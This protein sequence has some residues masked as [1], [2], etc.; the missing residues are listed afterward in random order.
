MSLMISEATAETRNITGVSA[1]ARVRA[2][3]L[4]VCSLLASS[5]SLIGCKSSRRPSVPSRPHRGS[6]R[7]Q[8]QPPRRRTQPECH[9]AWPSGV[10]VLAILSFRS[11]RSGVTDAGLPNNLRRQDASFT[12]TNLLEPCWNALVS[13]GADSSNGK[14][15]TTAK[16]SGA[17]SGGLRRT[18]PG[19]AAPRSTR[20][21]GVAGSSPLLTGRHPGTTT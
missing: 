16:T 15:R 13:H 14:C 18:H 1:I 9:S 10:G 21:S 7:L 20:R 4:R 19:H 8:P 12:R 5:C 2:A 6:W 11:R 17:F 3:A